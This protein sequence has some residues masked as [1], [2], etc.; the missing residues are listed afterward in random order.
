MDRDTFSKI[1]VDLKTIKLGNRSFK[2]FK[3]ENKCAMEEIRTVKNLVIINVYFIAHY[4]L[5]LLTIKLI[6][7]GI[8]E[9]INNI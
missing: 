4:N 7:I 3:S 9:H 8:N 2:P 6:I 5:Q 1:N